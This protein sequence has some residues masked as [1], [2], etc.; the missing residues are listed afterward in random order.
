M[1]AALHLAVLRKIKSS[2]SQPLEGMV[3]GV[4]AGCRPP[5]AGGQGPWGSVEL[6]VR[7][8]HK[9]G[10]GRQGAHRCR[11]TARRTV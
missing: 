5:R 6:R 4:G 3:E 9:E 7:P 8:G 11:T 2:Q 1:R 10:S